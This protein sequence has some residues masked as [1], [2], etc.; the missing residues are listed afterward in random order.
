[1]NRQQRRAGGRALHLRKRLPDD[2][3]IDAELFDRRMSRD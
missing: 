3:D 2:D 1:M